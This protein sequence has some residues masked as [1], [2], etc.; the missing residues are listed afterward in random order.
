VHA[1]SSSASRPTNAL[2]RIAAMSAHTSVNIHEHVILLLL[3]LLV[4]VVVYA[5][6]VRSSAA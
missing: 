2:N 6:P 5:R 1:S 4:V 3:L